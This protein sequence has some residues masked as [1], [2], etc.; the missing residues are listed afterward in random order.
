MICCVLQLLT[1]ESD[2]TVNDVF[3]NVGDSGVCGF[4]GETEKET[5]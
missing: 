4:G 1:A 2:H 5:L 3:G